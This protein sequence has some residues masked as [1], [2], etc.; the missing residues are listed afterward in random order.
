M[1]A[2][3]TAV[4]RKAGHGVRK[5]QQEAI[6]LLAGL[7]VEHDAHAGDRVQHRS[8][9]ARDPEQPNL[10]QVHL[11]ASELHDEL[12]R[13]GFAIEPGDMG[14][15]VTTRGVDLLALPSGTRLWLGEKAVVEITGLRN[16][17]AQLD[18]LAPGLLGAVVE[19]SG[20]RRL[21]RKA[22]I[23]GIVIA[24]GEVKRG[25]AIEL[26]LPAPPH[27]PLEVV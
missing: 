23:M 10:R 13:G 1:S 5:Q 20:D 8:R 4:S 25:D 11:M 22:G 9:V 19:R 6:R 7:G 26:E 27:R 15:N 3:V 21:V 14:E 17:C 18:E 16:P 24:G 12:A 2:I